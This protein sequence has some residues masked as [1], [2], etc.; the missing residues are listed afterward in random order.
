MF[1][2]Q[3]FPF[4]QSAIIL[5]DL[6]S[7]CERPRNDKDVHDHHV[8]LQPMWMNSRKTTR[9][10]TTTTTTT[11]LL[12]NRMSCGRSSNDKDVHDH[13]GT[14]PLPHF[15]V[16]FLPETCMATTCTATLW[17]SFL[18]YNGNHCN[19][20][21]YYNFNTWCMIMKLNIYLIIVYFWHINRKM[22]CQW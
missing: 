2:I 5:L 6:D 12:Y 22:I 21:I 7:C 1:C 15:L 18:Q 3:F 17:L 20:R 11:S 14:F 16:N 13:M 19:F 10:S 9:T 4:Q 8:H